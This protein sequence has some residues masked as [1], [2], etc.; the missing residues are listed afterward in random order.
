MQ[1]LQETTGRSKRWF[2]TGEA[3]RCCGLSY[4]SFNNWVRYGFCYIIDRALK[5]KPGPKKGW[6]LIDKADVEE[7]RRYFRALRKGRWCTT[8][9]ASNETGFSQA[10]ISRWV[11]SGRC[12]L[13]KGSLRTR[14]H[15]GTGRPIQ[16]ATSDVRRLK[17]T[18]EKLPELAA[19]A[20]SDS[21]GG[22]VT[23]TRATKEFPIPARTLAA[24]RQ[25]APA[26]D[27]S[28]TYDRVW[29]RGSNNTPVR[30]YVYLRDDLQRIIAE[31]DAARHRKGEADWQT[32]PNLSKTL[33][34]SKQ[35]LYLLS[36][37]PRWELD[38]RPVNSREILHPE[39]AAKFRRVRELF[40]PDVRSV[41]SNRKPGFS[42]P[43]LYTL[44]EAAEFFPTA[45]DHAHLID[46]ISGRSK[47]DP[48]ARVLGI[49]KRNG[50]DRRG[51]R[52]NGMYAVTQQE[53]DQALRCLRDGG[54][55]WEQPEQLMSSWTDA[56]Q[57]GEMLLD[58]EDR[59]ILQ[60]IAEFKGNPTAER[61]AWAI[62]NNSPS[63][64]FICR[65]RHLREA[66]LI[67]NQGRGRGA[68]GYQLT[69]KGLHFLTSP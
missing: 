30:R 36:D 11:K 35:S 32:I 19:G 15:A 9:D 41:L 38:G 14:R 63:G 65:L 69:H 17:D 23:Q 58:D 24:Y 56:A 28:I 66:G 48:L 18:A 59:L 60:A 2:T 49:R 12:P 64:A 3:S 27:R 6:S 54:T 53:I 22:F 16:I 1:Q 13:L 7:V 42:E 52:R 39:T 47:S 67:F 40:V 21:R 8:A 62:G 51:L 34:Q 4:Y 46:V 31:Q 29:F 45:Y 25:F 10:T 33:K 37:G 26:L 55:A 57:P 44:R 61:L 5:T 43:E 50:V 20:F 68:T